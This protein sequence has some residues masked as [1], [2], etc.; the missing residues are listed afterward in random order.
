[1]E[2]EW[3]QVEIDR[4]LKHKFKVHAMQRR[5]NMTTV[6]QSLIELYNAGKLDELLAKKEASADKAAA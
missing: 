3:L 5:M 2:R 4:E 1:M 6:L